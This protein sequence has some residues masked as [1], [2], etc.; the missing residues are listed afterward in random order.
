MFKRTSEKMNLGL[1]VGIVLLAQSCGTSDP[2][3]LGV[4]ESLVTIHRQQ[5]DC[6]IEVQAVYESGTIRPVFDKLQANEESFKLNVAM[7]PSEENWLKIEAICRDNMGRI[8]ELGA[9]TLGIPLSTKV[10]EFSL[11]RLAGCTSAHWCPVTSPVASITQTA[12]WAG[13]S[14]HAWIVGKSG[15]MLSW[16]GFQWRKQGKSSF[17]CIDFCDVAGAL[18]SGSSGYQIWT[19]AIQPPG[20]INCV[21]AS[22]FNSYLDGALLSWMTSYAA[23]DQPSRIRYG[24]PGYLYILAG[25]YV[26]LYSG[27]PGGPVISNWSSSGRWIDLAV[28]RAAG[29]VMP[30]LLWT[31]DSEPK[32]S[33]V[34]KNTM[35]FNTSIPTP[36]PP[37]FTLLALG[38]PVSLSI[39]AEAA[40]EDI[41]HPSIWIAGQRYGSTPPV[42]LLIPEKGEAAATVGDSIP[43]T[44]PSGCFQIFATSPN[45]AYAACDSV[46]LRCSQNSMSPTCSP[47]LELETSPRDSLIGIYGS[48]NSAGMLQLWAIGKNGSIWL[49]EGPE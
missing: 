10:V 24:G 8:V 37:A 27:I 4:K 23:R 25:Q 19:S 20:N 47:V 28:S 39:A 15:K 26:R 33:Y 46:V 12:V 29:R 9:T 13:D 42:S 38:E 49:Y 16:D 14:R 17:E 31:K 21:N 18:P 1:L 45:V 41:D 43:R 35:D 22:L 44:S 2:G 32:L 34:M 5:P 7:V 3:S 11:Q 6:R 30:W 48:K 40:K 36:P